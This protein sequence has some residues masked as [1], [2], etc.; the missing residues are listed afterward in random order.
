MKSKRIKNETLANMYSIWLLEFNYKY[1]SD[2]VC[3]RAFCR[4]EWPQS[5]Y[6]SLSPSF[7]SLKCDTHSNAKH[8]RKIAVRKM[9]WF[10]QTK[11]S[12][13]AFFVWNIFFECLPCFSIIYFS[14]RFI[15]LVYFVN[16]SNIL[17]FS[18]CVNKRLS[19]YIERQRCVYFC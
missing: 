11:I 8:L 13:S 4:C 3:V 19:S 15:L 16:I 9:C 6:L 14:N 17:P 12:F 18:R 2:R 10:F 7:S 1:R 5:L